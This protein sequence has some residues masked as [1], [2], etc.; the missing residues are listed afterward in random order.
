[1]QSFPSFIFPR[2]A[3][4][5][6]SLV[7]KISVEISYLVSSKMTFR[8]LLFVYFLQHGIEVRKCGRKERRNVEG[9]EVEDT[10]LRALQK[11]L[12]KHPK[13]ILKFSLIQDRIL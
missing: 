1:M 4:E 9:G 8:N 5:R 12:R 6:P 11:I 3:D 10:K 13:N 2:I 7:P